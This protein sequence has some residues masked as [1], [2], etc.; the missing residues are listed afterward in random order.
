M[1]QAEEK[2][3]GEK[4]QAQQWNALLVAKNIRSRRM[5]NSYGAL[6]TAATDG[7]TRCPDM[8]EM[9]I[10]FRKQSK[11][12]LTSPTSTAYAKMVSKKDY[13]LLEDEN[14]RSID[15]LLEPCFHSNAFRRT[16][17]DLRN[18]HSDIYLQL[19]K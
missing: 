10:Q 9:R 13:D 15:I 19:H 14:N 11:Q 18:L 4:E 7:Y 5:K 12:S 2:G 6:S 17:E 16:S 1:Q 3:V 8:A